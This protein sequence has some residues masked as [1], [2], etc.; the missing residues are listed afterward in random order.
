[1]TNGRH[2]EIFLNLV[3]QEVRMRILFNVAD[4]YGITLA[5]AYLEITDPEAESLLDY[6]T[7]SERAAT[8]ALMRKYRIH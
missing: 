1:M 5:E 3:C 2:T 8:S 7:G 4:R 6:V